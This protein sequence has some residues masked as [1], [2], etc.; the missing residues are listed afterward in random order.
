MGARG[1]RALALEVG[2]LP[3]RAIAGS[4]V[5]AGRGVAVAVAFAGTGVADG[6]AVV[7][8]G[9]GVEA[10][11][12]VPDDPPSSTVLSQHDE[13]DPDRGVERHE[14]DGMHAPARPAAARPWPAWRTGGSPRRP[15]C[16]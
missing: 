8:T 2:L 4:G 15:T 13:A 9:C 5:A 3:R 12:G 16:A 1:T 7:R 11:F 10:G 14:Q 6:V